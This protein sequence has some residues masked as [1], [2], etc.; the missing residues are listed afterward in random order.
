[1]PKGGNDIGGVFVANPTTF[2]NKLDSI[3]QGVDVLHCSSENEGDI[4]ICF[5]YGTDGAI[6]FMVT[7]GDVPQ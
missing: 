6:M 4:A 3:S 2:G 7:S 5:P 1:M